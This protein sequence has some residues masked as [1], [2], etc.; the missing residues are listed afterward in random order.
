VVP[1]SVNKLLL[2]AKSSAKKGDRALAKSL[3]EEILK[4]FPENKS[5]RQ[6]LAALK[7]AKAGGALQSPT[8]EMIN[9][10]ISLYNEGQ[11]SEVVEQSQRLIRTFP[12][13]PLVW[14]VLGAAQKNLG[15]LEAA[16]IAFKKVT[17]LN[18]ENAE[19]FNNLGVILSEQDKLDE[20][21]NC[22]TTAV[23][24]KPDYADALKNM[25]NAF[26]LQGRL[27]EGME[28]FNKALLQRPNYAQISNTYD[29]TQKDEV[30]SNGVISDS[31]GLFLEKPYETDTHEKLVAGGASESAAYEEG[32]AL[33]Q[34]IN[35]LKSDYEATTR[36]STSPLVAVRNNVISP[37]E[38]A[39][40][41]E[42]AKPLMNQA[43]VVGQ[44]TRDDISGERTGWSCYLAFDRDEVVNSIGQRIADIIG[45]P[46]NQAEPMQVIY[47]GPGQEYRPHFDAFDLNTLE[48]QEA[49]KKGGQRLVTSL[50]YLNKVESGGSTWFP[51]L[52][53]TVP[54]LP[55]R[56]LIFHNTTNDLK[57]RHPLSKHA[58]MPVHKGEKWAFNLWFRQY[59][60]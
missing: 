54:A 33:V 7:G 5:A 21:I 41:I 6:G 48:G 1:M 57:E 18:P 58:G 31:D 15:Y 3:Y 45:Y 9:K 32:A 28:C 43:A 47:Y 12:E 51:Q 34:G 30:T 23:T 35:F 38:S 52:Q 50:V 42:L 17:E 11:F 19:G 56:M 53:I 46:L 16:L 14:N 40:L 26:K 37:I 49:A 24:L 20:A 10:L 2:K 22:Y 29:V 8:Q 59:E 27:D 4:A 44:S 25:G 13:E 60:T 36:Y 39:Y 55:G